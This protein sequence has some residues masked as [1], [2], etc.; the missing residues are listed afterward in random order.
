LNPK[1]KDFQDY[2]AKDITVCQRWL[3]SFENFLEDMGECPPGMQIDRW[4]N[5]NGNYE[6][7]NCRWATRLQQARNKL[8]NRMCNIRGFSGCLSEV[9]EHFGANY[10]R[11]HRRLTLGWSLDDAIFSAKCFISEPRTFVP[12]SRLRC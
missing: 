8:D 5:K 3:E 7:G 1:N 10:K 12:D 4:P 6:P 9:C 11:V 2:G